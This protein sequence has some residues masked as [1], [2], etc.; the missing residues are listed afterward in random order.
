MCQSYNFVC[1]DAQIYRELEE[2]SKARVVYHSASVQGPLHGVPV[3]ALYQ[4][5]GVLDQK[6]LLARK[7]NTTYC[8][9]FP[10]VNTI[11]GHL[12]I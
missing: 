11:N 3:N 8:Y 9:D 1:Y 4:P 5:L 7:S 12:D 2:T 6:R 10:L